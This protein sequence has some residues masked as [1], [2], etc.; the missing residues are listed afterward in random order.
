[1]ITLNQLRDDVVDAV[2]EVLI[3]NEIITDI[4]ELQQSVNPDTGQ[5]VVGRVNGEPII[6][7]ASDYQ[8][9]NQN[10]MNVVGAVT[11]CL[12]I[13]EDQYNEFDPSKVE[14]VTEEMWTTRT[15]P[16]DE[17]HSRD[18]YPLLRFNLGDYTDNEYNDGSFC[19][20]TDIGVSDTLHNLSQLVGLS[21]E[22]T[23]IDPDLAKEVL[24]TNIR[25]LIP[26]QFTRQQ[27]IN[28]FFS[29]YHRLKPPSPPVWNEDIPGLITDADSETYDMNSI[30]TDKENGYITRLD[31]W[32]DDVNTTK[33][34]QSLR[35]DLDLYLRDLDE[36]NVTEL[37]DLRPLYENKSEGYVKIRNLNQSIIIR[38]EEGDEVGLIGE[39]ENNPKWLENG[40]TI[41]MWVKFLDRVN[42]GTLFN[43]G[44]PLGVNDPKGF[45]LETFTLKKDD[46]IRDYATPGDNYW[47]DVTNAPIT[48][49]E[50]INYRT[51]DH[52][53][54]NLD[55]WNT[56]NSSP[57]FPDFNSWFKQND[58]ERF[59]RLVVRESNGVLRDSHVG[60]SRY[61]GEF[62]SRRYPTFPH[63]EDN[64]QGRIPGTNFLPKQ[65]LNYTRIPVDLDEWFFI[66]ANYNPSINE[67]NNMDDLGPFAEDIYESY[68][69]NSLTTLRYYPEFWK[70][71]IIPLSVPP[72]QDDI[73]D[74]PW[75]D[76]ALEGFTDDCNIIYDAEAS[77][78]WCKLGAYTHSSSY[79]AKCKVEFI[80]RSDLLRAKG[81]KV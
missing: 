17:G 20:N 7:S 81:F 78:R 45:M 9:A 21:N 73:D 59:V 22:I 19:I 14:Y 11:A 8:A 6:L 15:D 10:F 75:D 44:N 1:M 49:E 38:K 64:Q 56:N 16:A 69:P 54:Y 57:P 77:E 74:F 42:G 60:K 25:E 52:P 28:K 39:D 79:G 36:A 32:T 80:S 12:K 47:N 23:E 4:S 24:D 18:D 66:V 48:W 62:L 29:D 61:R 51:Q 53:D 65:L 43:F 50:Y 34:L 27:E 58:Y 40:F 30:S 3:A 31:Q 2:I 33:T 72:T 68:G 76:D 37:E 41:T 55:G 70:N 26:T 13:D 46:Y 35:N 5:I 63:T 67:G 71:N